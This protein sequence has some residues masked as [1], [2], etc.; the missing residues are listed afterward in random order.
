MPESDKSKVDCIVQRIKN[1][2]ESCGRINQFPFRFSVS[3]GYAISSESSDGR[4]TDLL[5]KADE[6]MYKDKALHHQ[7]K[8]TRKGG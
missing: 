3:V 1:G 7:K 6:T 4:I 5:K 2:F 8:H